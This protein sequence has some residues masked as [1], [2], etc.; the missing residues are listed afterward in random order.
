MYK[1]LT[2]FLHNPPVLLDLCSAA[3]IQALQHFNLHSVNRKAFAPTSPKKGAEAALLAAGWLSCAA[4]LCRSAVWPLIPVTFS[5]IKANILSLF[6]FVDPPPP[7]PKELESHNQRQLGWEVS[8]VRH[9]LCTHG[10]AWLCFLF[11]LISRLSH[12]LIGRSMQNSV[13]T[14]C[15]CSSSPR[16]ICLLDVCGQLLLSDNRRRWV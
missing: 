4:A 1:M 15:R 9:E 12:E 7:F 13:N 10:S 3:A 14:C 8:K 11:Q 5:T 6:V 16:L 2:C